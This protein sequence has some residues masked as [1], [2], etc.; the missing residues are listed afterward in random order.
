MNDNDKERQRD[1]DQTRPEPDKRSEAPAEQH[2]AEGTL[3]R[4]LTEDQQRDELHGGAAQRRELRNE[5]ERENE[6]LKR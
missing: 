6:K 1:L 4:G 2:R 5:A 3:R